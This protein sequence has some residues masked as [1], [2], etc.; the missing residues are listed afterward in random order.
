MNLSAFAIS[1]QSRKKYW[2]EDLGP[3]QRLLS[4][5]VRREVLRDCRMGM[6]GCF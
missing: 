1:V 3:Q 6:E 4:L 2:K 5:E